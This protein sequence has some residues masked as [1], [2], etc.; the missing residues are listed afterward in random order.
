MTIVGEAFIVISPEGASARTF[1]TKLD[2]ELQQSNFAGT[3][4]KQFANAGIT[5][6]NTFV[7]KFTNALK[8]GGASGGEVLGVAVVAAAVAGLGAIGAEFQKVR[9]QIQQETGATGTALSTLAND[10]T[11]AFRKVPVSLSTA[12]DAVDELRR[13]GV[14]LGPQLEQLAQQELFLA[15]ITKEQ[16]APTVDATTALFGKFNVATSDQSRELDVLFK[17]SQQSGKG[18]DVLVSGLT[19]GAASLQ[20]FGFGLDQSAALLAA[21]EKAGFNVTPVLAALRLGFGKI[22][23]AGGDPQKVLAGL[24]K[25]LTDGV[26]P[27]KG[28]ADAIHLFGTRSG[29]E[30]ATAIQKGAL[31]TKGLLQLI[32]DGKKGIVATGLATLT[33]GDQF[34][35]LRNNITADLAGVGT[36]ILHDLES[37]LKDAAGPV[38]SL[39]TGFGHLFVALA[40]AAEVLPLFLAPLKLILPVVSDFGE[41][42]SVIATGLELIPG[43]ARAVVVGLLALEIGLEVTG[44]GFI[45]AAAAATAFGVAVDFATGPVGIAIGVIAG[46]GLAYKSFT[47]DSR[48]TA[49]EAKSIGD[50]LFTSTSATS[51]FRTGVTNITK[52]LADFITAGG[53]AS[54]VSTSLKGEL[55]ATGTTVGALSKAVTGSGRAWD[56]YKASVVDAA[57]KAL[58]AWERAQ[59]RFNPLITALTTNLDQQRAAFEKSAKSTLSDAIAN[60]ELTKSQ[61]AAAE[62]STRNTDGSTNYAKA[63]TLLNK[64]LTAAAVVQNRVTAARAS[65]AV[66]ED[67]LSRQIAAG[68]I[69]DDSA[70][71]ALADLGFTGDAVAIQ[72]ARLKDRATELNQ[73]QDKS[74]FSA[75]QGSVAYRELARQI[76]TGSIVEQG[77]I[78]KL[79]GMHFS[80]DGAKTAFQDLQGQ[81]D[82]FVQGAVSQIPTAAAAI[83]TINDAISSD[84][85]TLQ[86]DR[87]E[88]ASL[89]KQLHDAIV[90]S[91]ASTQKQLSTIDAKIVTDQDR[92]RTGSVSTTTT[93]DADLRR[94]TAILQTAATNG[95]KASASLASSIAAN[96]KKIHDDYAK[97]VAD[98]DPAKFTKLVITN[99]VQTATF[100][101]NLQKLV[102]EGFGQLAG[103]LAQ[104]GP[105]AA[106]ALAAGFASN[107]SKAKV[108]NA[109]V[110][111][112][113]QTTNS[114]TAFLKQNFPELALATQQVGAQVGKGIGTGLTTELLKLF[115]QLRP[116]FVTVGKQIADTVGDTLSEH[117]EGFARFGTTGATTITSSLRATLAAHREDISGLF[118]D[119]GHDADTGLAKGITDKSIDVTK[120]INAVADGAIA[121][122]RRSFRSHSPSLVFR[123]IGTDI[124]D[125]LVAGLTASQSPVSKAMTTLA[126]SATSSFSKTLSA[127]LTKVT[128]SA[129]SSAF[130]QVGHGTGQGILDQQGFE[131]QLN[132]IS[133]RFSGRTKRP[134]TQAPPDAQTIAA[135]A[136]SLQVTGETGLSRADARA[137]FDKI[138]AA[139]RPIEIRLEGEQVNPL[140]IAAELAWAMK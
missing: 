8:I 106:G 120:A 35:L 65:T 71:K 111:L 6:G 74:A 91:A 38:E 51:L 90:S 99:A 85:S 129:V 79:N 53:S 131:E 68:T 31:S 73:Q 114:Y 37:G 60:D 48:N 59:G 92:I 123:D 4:D 94:R 9:A 43:P 3:L 117:D 136:Q 96:N 107:E 108:A 86:S 128:K 133:R 118:V 69:T 116:L 32:T 40:P 61:V 36:I 113:Q 137:E 77:A 21:L 127:G 50:A 55:V 30:L 121:A 16:V 39:A 134:L 104:Q 20:K 57:T 41:G 70:K 75:A 7:S 138:A 124:G 49:A 25:E 67:K 46:L 100:M 119:L 98:N 97:L 13:R 88:Q 2:A 72:L 22:A 83:T 23:Q 5:G 80:A 45:G 19:T 87:S 28:M 18:L 56:S 15:K 17:A 47:A 132:D 12:A 76:A 78:D 135:L 33:L 58:P 126:G 29:V 52:G 89:N 109:A 84:K 62:A 82:A 66:A 110:T 64:Q 95:G 139:A 27:A 1:A 105:A 44:T 115:P 112:G 26:N 24:V 10:V 11:Q 63:I 81:I 130:G 103:T 122:A 54:H 42:L 140:F 93:L 34:R 101:A 125:G 102:T 14:P